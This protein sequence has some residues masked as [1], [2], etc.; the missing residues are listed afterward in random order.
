MNFIVWCINHFGDITIEVFIFST[1]TYWFTVPVDRKRTEKLFLVGVL[2]I[3]AEAV[4]VNGIRFLAAWCP[5]KYDLYLYG[6]DVN[7]FHAP[8]FVIG[9]FLNKHILLK[10]VVVAVYNNVTVFM[11][12]A[13]MANLYLRNEENAK[14][15]F[16]AFI[17]NPILAILLYVTFPVAGPVYA[18]G[19]NFPIA[20]PPVGQPHLLRLN[21]VPNGVPSVHVSIALMVLWYLRYWWWGRIIGVTFLA[22]TVL[23]TLGLGEHYLID[24]IAAIPYAALVIYLSSIPLRTRCNLTPECENNQ[25]ID[26][27]S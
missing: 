27:R 22:L 16:V 11:L 19:A 1:G 26:R 18:F 7:V 13:F 12:V 14:D 6:L 10:M 20:T 2:G 23:A 5:Y 24:L 15:V 17:L 8:G 4:N 3:V 9:R 25:T 21:A